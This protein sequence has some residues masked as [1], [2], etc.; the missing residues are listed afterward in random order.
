V[1]EFATLA[2]QL[3]ASENPSVHPLYAMAAQRLFLPL[4]RPLSYVVLISEALLPFGLLI[5]RLTRPSAV[6]GA[7][8][9]VLFLMGGEARDNPRMLFAQLI[10][11]AGHR[12]K[13]DD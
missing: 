4:A 6:F 3:A 13:R 11:I 1:R 12:A 7:L 8:L 5:P 2:I 10:V 9:N